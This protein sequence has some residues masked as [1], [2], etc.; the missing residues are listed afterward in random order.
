MYLFSALQ[1]QG[2]SFWPGLE[3]CTHGVQAGHELA[4]AEGVEH[5]LPHA[6]HDAHV[7]DDVG[8]VGDLDADV[9]DG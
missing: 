2:T 9:R 3:R 8:R 5:L 1:G 4:V 6:R 7:G